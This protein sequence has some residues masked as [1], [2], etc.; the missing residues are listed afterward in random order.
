[1]HILISNDDGYSA[2]GIEALANEMRRFGRVT[3]VAPERN[4]S[5][6]SNA[7]TLNRPL[8]VAK[9]SDEVY[10]VSGTP[11]DCVHLALTG[12]LDDRPDLVV[13]GI[14]CGANMGDDTMYS[15]TVAAAVEGYIF[16]IDSIAFSQIDKGWAELASAAAMAGRIVERFLQRRESNP[17]EP[18]L[19][20]VN[21]PN[22]PM[23][24]MRGI[25][26]TRLGRR[27]SAERMIHEVNP[28]GM[29]IYWLGAA[30]KPRDASEG[31]DFWATQHGFV[32]VTPL[33]VDLTSHRQ[34]ADAERLVSDTPPKL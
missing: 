19:L 22:L 28:R 8:T 11:S 7:L 33:Q 24:A 10:V 2:L 23:H 3:I 29:P 18:M 15:G 32:S 17:R 1:M 31:T 6:S 13:S 14:N 21:M 27:H 12:L 16:G 30:G 9:A 4:Q 20:N 25:R 34:I 5:G 26:T